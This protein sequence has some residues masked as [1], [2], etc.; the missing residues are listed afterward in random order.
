VEIV[1]FCAIHVL[2]RYFFV[3]LRRQMILML[4]IQRDSSKDIIEFLKNQQMQLTVRL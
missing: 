4:R 1:Y 3:I 2:R